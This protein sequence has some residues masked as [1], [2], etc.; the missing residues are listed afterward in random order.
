MTT[1]LRVVAFTPGHDEI[2]GAARHSRLLCEELARRGWDVRVVTRSAASTRLRVRR[3]RHLLVVEVPGCGGRRR[4][5]LAFLLIS[6]ALG[7]VWG[8]RTAVL[9]S[10]QLVS[11]T[12]AAAL[13]SRLTRRPFVAMSTTSGSLSETSSLR[14]NS[15]GPRLRRQLLHR[16]SYVIA[17]T[18][19]AALEVVDLVPPGRVAVLPT[20]VESLPAWPLLGSGSALFTGRFSAEKSLPLLL[21]AWRGVVGRRPDARLV[22]AGEG[23][24]YRSVESQVRA[25][26]AADA[27]LT[28]SVEF[29][30]WVEDVAGLLRQHDVYVFP[31]SSEG[32]SNSLVE[33]CAAARAVVASDIAPNRAVLGDDYPGLFTDGDRDEL[34]RVLGA[35]LTDEGLRMTAASRAVDGA[36]RNLLSNVGDGLERLLRSA[37]N[38]PRP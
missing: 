6:L 1:P 33:A 4:G 15:V 5:A 36:R 3:Q 16:A 23:G 38:R 12:T 31:S 18:D 37:A 2:G 27:A 10:F 28:A 35:M 19:E 20:P 29:P 11:P 13:V 9:L 14:G 30:G 25:A 7:V 8:R 21:D 32:M 22:L 24:S 17:Q 26:V 34:E